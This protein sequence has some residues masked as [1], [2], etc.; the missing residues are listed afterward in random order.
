MNSI[1]TPSFPKEKK[2]F[3][4]PFLLCSLAFTSV[5]FGGTNLIRFV[6]NDTFHPWT[7]SAGSAVLEAEWIVHPDGLAPENDF[8]LTAT[9]PHMVNGSEILFRYFNGNAQFL[10]YGWF[11]NYLTEEVMEPY[12]GTTVI[13]NQ[14]L[15]AMKYRLSNVR[16]GSVSPIDLVCTNHATT[17]AIASNGASLPQSTIYVNAGYTFATAGKIQV[18]T[19]AGSPSLDYT[20]TTTD[21]NGRTVS[22]TGCSGGTGTLAT[23]NAVA[24]LS[25]NTSTAVHFHDTVYLL[26][27]EQFAWDVWYDNEYDQTAMLHDCTACGNVCGYWGPMFESNFSPCATGELPQIGV[28]NT[29][30]SVNGGSFVQG[31]ASNSFLDEDLG[32]CGQEK[33]YTITSYLENYQWVIQSR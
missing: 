18:I 25:G 30:V 6:W 9:T 16:S 31:S 23:G 15:S 22:F 28:V 27:Y 21:G 24:E 29:R 19:S 14:T 32:A 10:M 26:N 13:N 7:N 5:A 4:L 20:G 2:R 33:P 8:Y 1:Q 3:L 12:I 11:E 17:I